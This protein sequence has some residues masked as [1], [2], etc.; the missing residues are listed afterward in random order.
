MIK[1]YERI[2]N[3]YREMYLPINLDPDEEYYYGW[4]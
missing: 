3:D 2:G 1:F 4:W